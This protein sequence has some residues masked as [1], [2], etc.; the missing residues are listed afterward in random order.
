M[1]SNILWLSLDKVLKLV[2]GLIVGIWVARYLGPSQWGE[3]NYVL[4]FITIA[5]TV[6]KLGMDGFLIKEILEHPSKKNEIL[7]TSFFMRLLIIPFVLGAILIYF[8]LL[9]LNADYY[10]LLA[11]LSLNVFITPLDLIDLDFQSKLQS[12]LTVVS[13][14][15]AYVLGA[16]LRV[17]L[18]VS[19]KPLVWFAAG[20]GFEALLSYIFLTILYQKNNNI[21][22]WT[23]S[24]SLAK[25]LLRAGWPFTL[26]SLAVILYMRI[27]QVMLGSMVNEKELG[28]FS[29]A[30]K[31][32]D[33]FIFLPMA[34]SSSYLPSL[35]H[36]KKTSQ[37]LFIRKNQF[38]INWMARISIVLAILVTLFSDQIIQ[39]LYGADYMQASGILVIHIW[40]LVPMFLGV[41]TSQYLIIENLQKFSLYRTVLGL[42]FN[43]LLNLYLIPRYGAF[44]AAFAT[45]ISQFVA[46]V[47]SM[48]LF[49]QTR[50][51]F[52]MQLRS[53]TMFFNFSL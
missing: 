30:I 26:S 25:K 24:I 36:A 28:L 38:F 22:Q 7:G 49:Q 45:T 1:V 6:G 16:F 21:F 34:V 53:L 48:A 41:A 37:E 40:S 11:F 15:T 46:A 14:N 20:M 10:W 39:V 18:L 47:F 3:L 52:K 51:L 17:Y 23:V 29:S 32:S 5:G 12:K 44:G 35:V 2:I 4:A 19:N 8:Y 43:V 33:I 9:N 50:I 31:I 42:I 27:D 13:K